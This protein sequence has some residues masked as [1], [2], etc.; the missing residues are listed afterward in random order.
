MVYVSDCVSH[1]GLVNDCVSTAEPLTV[2][3][4]RALPPAV[5]PEAGGGSGE[6]LKS[7]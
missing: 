2:A 6:L 3:S 7:H 5:G 1:L 4:Q